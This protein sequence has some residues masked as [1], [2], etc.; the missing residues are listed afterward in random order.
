MPHVDQSRLESFLF[1]TDR[2]ALAPV[3]PGLLDLH[4]I[5]WA[6]Y[7]D[8]GIENLVVADAGC[9]GTG[10]R[11]RIRRPAKPE[12]WLSTGLKSCAASAER[13]AVVARVGVLPA[14]FERVA[15]DA[16]VGPAPGATGG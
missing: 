11:T 7:P 5:P 10:R 3:R 4:F 13:A 6:R 14:G 12:R 16:G 9:N 1:G 2:I 15:G 8:D